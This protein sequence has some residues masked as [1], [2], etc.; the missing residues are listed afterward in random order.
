MGLRLIKTANETWRECA[1]RY[2]SK[3]FLE[4]EVLKI[5]DYDLAHGAEEFQA[6]YDACYEW[7]VLD[8]FEDTKDNSGETNGPE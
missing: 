7:D 8:Y 6:A 3:Y 5:Y 1:A 4:E 2:G